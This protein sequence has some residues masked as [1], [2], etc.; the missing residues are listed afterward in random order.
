MNG[1]NVFKKEQRSY[2]LFVPSMLTTIIAMA[3]SLF[4]EHMQDHDVPT[5]RAA[6]EVIWFWS[7]SPTL[8][9]D[10]SRDRHVEKVH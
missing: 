8:I 9:Q 7:F 10:R 5:R 1:L 2:S 6:V 4:M 3:I